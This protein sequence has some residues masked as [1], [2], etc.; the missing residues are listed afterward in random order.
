MKS[1]FVSFHL[2]IVWKLRNQ[3]AHISWYLAFHYA[4][5]ALVQGIIDADN[6][7]SFTKCIVTLVESCRTAIHLLHTYIIV[8]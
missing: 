2:A 7:A 3:S 8:S 4:Q 6:F 1:F 5:G